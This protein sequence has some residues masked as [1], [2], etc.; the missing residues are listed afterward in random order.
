MKR[1]KVKEILPDITPE[2]LDKLMDMSGSEIS[3][4][5]TTIST[6]KDDIKVKDGVISAKNNKIT[7]LS[8]KVDSRSDEDIEKIKKS[9]YER[10]KK[11]MG[12][13]LEKLKFSNA[14]DGELSKSGAKNVKA[15][16]ALLNMDGIKYENDTLTGLSE[17]LETIKKENAYMFDDEKNQSNP[18]FTTDTSQ[19]GSITKEAFSKMSYPER[20]QVYKDDPAAYKELSN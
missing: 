15:L 8:E 6:L 19:S 13:E 7:E 5:K 16:K 3:E 4:L 18:H 10:G 1:E 9:E 14:L 2:Q 12:A 20:L 11:E 17:Q